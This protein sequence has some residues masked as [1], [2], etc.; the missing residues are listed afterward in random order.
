MSEELVKKQLNRL[1]G[2][3]H[4]ERTR[5]ALERGEPEREPEALGALA[6]EGYRSHDPDIHVSVYVFASWS[7]LQPVAKQ[8]QEELAADGVHVAIAS[9]GP[10]LF[11]GHTRIDGQGGTNARFALGDIVSAFA[12]D[13]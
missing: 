12:G 1:N 7:E 8:L 3:M 2:L 5:V 13:E 10:M 11:V 9:N 6:G 4:P